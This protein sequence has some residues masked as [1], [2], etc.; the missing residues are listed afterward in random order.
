MF[1]RKMRLSA[2]TAVLLFY[3]A[4]IISAE[5]HSTSSRTWNDGNIRCTENCDSN[6]GC[7]TSCINVQTGEQVAVPN[8]GVGLNPAFGLLSLSLMSILATYF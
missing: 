1:P 6:T 2:G 8:E 4:I 5:M 3:F 7:K